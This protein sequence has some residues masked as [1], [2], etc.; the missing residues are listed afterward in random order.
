[1]IQRGRAV[2]RRVKLDQEEAASSSVDG[3]VARSTVEPEKSHDREQRTAPVDRDAPVANN[4]AELPGVPYDELQ[5][6]VKDM[7]ALAENWPK[8]A[9]IAVFIKY[10]IFWVSSYRIELADT[11]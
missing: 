3:D 8:G 5:T 10:V 7:E 9:L 4:G 1:L 11:L 6:G 2:F